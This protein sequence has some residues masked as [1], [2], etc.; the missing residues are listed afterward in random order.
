MATSFNFDQTRPTWVS[1]SSPNQ[2]GT[3]IFLIHVVHPADPD[4]LW[5]TD[6]QAVTYN[7]CLRKSD[8]PAV[9]AL[10]WVPHWVADY[11]TV[12]ST[13]CGG[14]CSQNT[15]CAEPGCI[16]DTVKQICVEHT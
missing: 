16:C 5:R 9:K 4:A 1:Q 11:A 6:V 2:V 14:P 3:G 8:H 13:K 7:Y 10:K 15:G 12:I